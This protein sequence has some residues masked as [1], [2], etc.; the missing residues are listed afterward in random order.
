MEI[1]EIKTDQ[2]K[3]NP[4]QPRKEFDKE[5]LQELADSIKSV[6]LINPIHVTQL[7][8]TEYELISGERRLKAHKLANL[9]TIKAIIEDLTE[10]ENHTHSLV[11][12]LHREDLSDWDKAHSIK[13]M[14]D[15]GITQKQIGK[16]LGLHQSSIGALLSVTKE[17]NKHLSEAVKNKEITIRSYRDIKGI[18]N[19]EQ[20]TKLLNKI[21]TEQIKSTKIRELANVI[22]NSPTDVT[23]AMFD[24]NISTEQAQTISKI[25][26]PNV[27]RKLI[28]THQQIKTLDRNMDKNVLRESKL[29]VISNVVRTKEALEQF[30]SATIEN[31]KTTTTAI[32]SLL[33]CHQLKQ[34][35]DN[36]QQAKLKHYQEL[37]NNNIENVLQLSENAGQTL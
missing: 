4:F 30:R 5:K 15:K 6:G 7:S 20:E 31:Q 24:D 16:M 13:E 1:Q 3:P 32:R 17:R 36:K 34:L 10:T 21:V 2:I 19:P 35:M 27:R 26:N 22:K 12:N 29:K 33:K 9:P 11:E 23:Q 18:N 14:V 8:K 25:K 28:K 37:F